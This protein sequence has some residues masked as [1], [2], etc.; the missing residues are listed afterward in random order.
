[1]AY[2]RVDANQGEVVEALEAV[3]AVVK[4]LAQTGDGVTDLLVW[5]RGAYYLLEVKD[6]SKPPSARKL[7]PAQV[8]FHKLF[9]AAAKAGKLCIVLSP[10]QALA[11]VGVEVKG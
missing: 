10:Q 4:V 11:A 3:G 9:E 1:M 5:F 6:G 2:G 8:V 7:T